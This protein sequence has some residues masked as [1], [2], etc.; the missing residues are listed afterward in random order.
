MAVNNYMISA[1]LANEMKR[2]YLQQ[3]ESFQT[4]ANAYNFTRYQVREAMYR[5]MT[6][7]DHALKTRQIAAE[8]SRFSAEHSAVKK[9]RKTSPKGL[10]K[11][12]YKP[13]IEHRAAPRRNIIYGPIEIGSTIRYTLHLPV[14]N[15][16]L[17]H[18]A[19]TE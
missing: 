14:A 11:H 18:F 16:S 7:E 17:L 9:L 2:L 15:E 3:G 10:N 12:P 1:G 5:V 13:D 8:R 6:D 19:V 4:V